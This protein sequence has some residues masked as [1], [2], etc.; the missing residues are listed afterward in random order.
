[1]SGPFIQHTLQLITTCHV[2]RVTLNTCLQTGHLATRGLQLLQR[3]WPSGHCS[4]GG[5]ASSKQMGHSSS[6]SM[7]RP[8]YILQQQHSVQEGATLCN[9][10]PPGRC[11]QTAGC[12]WSLGPVLQ[13]EPQVRDE[14]VELLLALLHLPLLD[15]AY[16][17]V[18]N[19][20]VPF[21]LTW[22]E[23]W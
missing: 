16:C 3:M 10:R 4:T 12:G 1:M 14:G 19:K 13:L 9:V 2:S 20:M 23:R 18:S 7:L 5:L 15:T 17:K 11:H 21:V 6:A 22:T 8:S